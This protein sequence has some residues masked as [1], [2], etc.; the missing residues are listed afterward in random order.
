MRTSGISNTCIYVPLVRPVASQRCCLLGKIASA[1]SIALVI[2]ITSQIILTAEGN[3]KGSFSEIRSALDALDRSLGGCIMEFYEKNLGE[4]CEF[5]FAELESSNVLAV[6]EDYL[7]TMRNDGMAYTSEG[8]REM[9]DM[10]R[11]L[12]NHM[13]GLSLLTESDGQPQ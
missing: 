12:Q 10:R 5:Y 13:Q 4:R 3:A 1:K 8:Q 11:Q 7:K 2:L 9:H 6:I